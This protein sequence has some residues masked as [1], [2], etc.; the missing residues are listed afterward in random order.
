MMVHIIF[1]FGFMAMF[2]IEAFTVSNE[3]IHAGIGSLVTCVLSFFIKDTR[4]LPV[5]LLISALLSYAFFGRLVERVYAKYKVRAKAYNRLRG[6][7]AICVERIDKTGGRIVY[8][9]VY[10]D[11][12]AKS[13]IAKGDI[14]RLL[15]YEE[16]A[17]LVE[18]YK[19]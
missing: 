9:G 3:A 17:W 16:D 19:H 7:R 10:H 8:H 4:V 2:I 5:S 14:V 1:L 18:E 13:D 12:V 15:N 6:K 11:A